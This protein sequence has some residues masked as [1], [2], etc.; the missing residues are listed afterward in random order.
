M[1][2]FGGGGFFGITLDPHGIQIL[3]AAFEFGASISIDFGVA[4][5][6]VY[7]M[8]GIYFRMEQDACSL[9]G[10]FRLGGH[11]DV[12]GLITA[13]LEL[14]LELRYEFETGKCVGTATLTIEIE[15]FMFSGSVT[16]TCEKK[17][18][19][20]NGDPTFRDLMGV[21]PSLT[22]AD[23]LASIDDRHRVCV[24]RLLRSV[25]LHEEAPHG[26]DSRL[27]GPCCRTAAI[28]GGPAGGTPAAS[29]SSCRR[30]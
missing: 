1:T 21:D 7:V 12:L 20:S 26:H 10:Y 24:A 25:R 16:I 6:G 13:S 27:S 11:V 18:A 5:G 8:A 23:E 17:F 15:V 4:S 22:L 3:E 14:Y 19:G 2:L 29:R 28:D 30:G 9:T